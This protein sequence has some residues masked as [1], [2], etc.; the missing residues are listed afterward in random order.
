MGCTALHLAAGEGDATTIYRL[1]EH[2]AHIEQPHGRGY[3]PLAAAC[4]SGS[5]PCVQVLLGAGAEIMFHEATNNSPLHYAVE[6][7]PEMIDLL[8]S[9]GANVNDADYQWKTTPLARAVAEDKISNCICIL[10]NGASFEISDWEG[11]TP[12]N[13]SILHNAHHTFDFPTLK[14]SRLSAYQLCRT[15]DCLSYCY[16]W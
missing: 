10:K 3:T 2:G 16:A 13:E 6:Q 5:I 8:V 15:N 4:R 14:E 7:S 9:Y 1:I 12:L 11:D